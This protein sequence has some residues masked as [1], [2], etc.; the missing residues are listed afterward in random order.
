[1]NIFKKWLPLIV[2][3]IVALA[4]AAALYAWKSSEIDRLQS[5]ANAS[6]IGRTVASET[7]PKQRRAPATK[8][9]GPEQARLDASLRPTRN[10]MRNLF[11]RAKHIMDLDRDELLKLLDELE[12]N[13]RIR[14][15]IAGVNLM[16]AYAR[17]AEIDPAGAMQRAL[18][19]KGEA[20]DMAMATVMN[21]W[22]AKDRKGALAWFASS[23]DTESKKKYL[24]IASITNGGA[25]PELI[26]E[27]S[28]AISDP[29]ARSKALL[30]SI[31]ALAFSDPDAA[32]KKLAEIEDPDEREKAG[33]RV[34]EGFLM[35]YP[36]KALDFAMSQ[37]PGD[38]ARENARNSLVR[39]GEQDAGAAL[40]WLTTQSKDVQK[41]LF[42]S[43]EGKSPGWG[44][45]KA[46]IEEIGM[47]ARQLGD[48]S[49]QD[50]LY[51]AWANSQSWSKPSD[52][53]NQ[54]SQIK[55][56]ELQ[57]A[58]ASSIGMAAAQSG[59]T[60]DMN[61]WLETAI[62]NDTRDTAV[63][64]FAKGLAQKDAP[65][66][67]EFAGR[68][69]NGVIREETLN[70]LKNPAPVDPTQIPNRPGRRR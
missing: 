64:S 10:G 11:E 56:P 31:G 36:Q 19:Q 60:S 16:T 18:S 47:A 57:K 33:E 34:Y 51:A 29:E 25:D 68:I 35:R 5:D 45:G 66:A 53:L 55:D 65:A 67:A 24:T 52:G 6:V 37:P 43:G 58:T 32:L 9:G 27:L 30:D 49:Q 1:M 70:A 38:K 44:F 26:T 20:K 59:K 62:P 61:A 3:S 15:P 13:G 63:A 48:Q 17:L 23:E 8:S 4:A 69:T 40:K 41:E 2:T 50:K 7:G 28:S 14:S 39:W 42:D 12:V 54:L 46:S 22:L 21:E